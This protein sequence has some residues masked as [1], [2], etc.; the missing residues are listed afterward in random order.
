M[1]EATVSAVE[2]NEGKIVRRWEGGTGETFLIT[3]KGPIFTKWRVF[4]YD[5]GNAWGTQRE[6]LGKVDTQ[7]EACFAGLQGVNRIECEKV[8]KDPDLAPYI[9]WLAA[10]ASPPTADATPT[11]P[12]QP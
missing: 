6:V 7:L 2:A 5:L 1:H 9:T 12:P 8:A 10:P 11:P 4:D 3:P